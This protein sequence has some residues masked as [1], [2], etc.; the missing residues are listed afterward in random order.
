MPGFYAENKWII[1]VENKSA[2][3]K[4]AEVDIKWS[5]PT[6]FGLELTYSSVSM[7]CLNASKSLWIISV[8]VTGVEVWVF[9]H[10]VAA[11]ENVKFVSRL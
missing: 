7:R 6:H 1:W 11:I 4:W 2:H 8:E 3:L 9:L 10:I 5:T